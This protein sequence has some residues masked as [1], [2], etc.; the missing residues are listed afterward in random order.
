MN[1]YIQRALLAAAL[2]GAVY[3]I[4]WIASDIYG[5]GWVTIEARV[6]GRQFIP[7]RSRWET[8]TY[9]CGSGESLRRCSGRR[10]VSIPAEYRVFCVEPDGTQ[11]NLDDAWGFSNLADGGRVVL[12]ARVGRSGFR[13]STSI[14]RERSPSIRTGAR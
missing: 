5:G 4:Y 14:D 6:V 10:Y 11:R 8:Y 2:T 12:R 1:E 3:G 13:W 7:D 9:S